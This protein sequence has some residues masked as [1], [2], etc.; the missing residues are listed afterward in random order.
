MAVVHNG[1]LLKRRLERRDAAAEK[2]LAVHHSAMHL[3]LDKRHQ[4]RQSNHPSGH[5]KHQKLSCGELPIG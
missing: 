3:M 2:S 5:L 1:V 4:H